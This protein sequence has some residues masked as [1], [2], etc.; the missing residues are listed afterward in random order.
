MLA[1]Q[2]ELILV[3]TGLATCGALVLFLAPVATMKMLFGQA[4]PTRSAS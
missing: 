2:I 3:L 1:A 4:P